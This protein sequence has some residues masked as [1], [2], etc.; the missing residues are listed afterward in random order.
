MSELAPT[1]NPA[2]FTVLLVEDSPME[3]NLLRAM[4]QQRGFQVVEAQNG[5]E[6]LLVL[7]KERP[8]AVVSDGVMP[9]LDG[10]QFCR[11]LKDDPATRHIPLILLTGQA[12]GLSRF[13]ARVC[14]ADRFLLKGRESTRVVEATVDL[15]ASL[16]E[17]I[18]RRD[19]DT[20]PEV[21]NWGHELGIDAIQLRLGKALE[22]QLL[23]T[24]MRGTIS[25]LATHRGTGADAVAKVLE[26]LH[27]LVL[28]GALHIVIQGE[29]GPVGFGRYGDA[30]G[31]EA[32]AHIEAAA[33]QSLG[34]A[35]P[36]PSTWEHRPPLTDEAA[37]LLDPI[38]FS[39]PIG[40]QDRPVLAWL[41]VN[42]GSRAFQ[43]YERLFE[44]ACQELGRLLDLIE[45][46]NRMLQAEEA[47]R[48]A[49]KRGSLAL[50][51]GGVAHDFNNLFQSI[52]AHVQVAE[53]SLTD[54][55]GKSALAK[56]LTAV[57]RGADLGRR[58]LE[59]SGCMWG[60]VVPLDLN[61]LVQE[62]VGAH[63]DH[64]FTLELSEALP[65]IAGDPGQLRLALS[66]LVQ[67]AGEAIGSGNGRI[68]VSTSLS[69][70]R[71]LPGSGGRW[72]TELPVGR[73]VTIAVAD[74]G[75]GASAKVLERMFDPFFS[76]KQ[77]GR[78][79]S[80]AATLGI[81]KA[82]RAALQVE[83]RVGEGTTFHLW[84]PLADSLQ[85][86]AAPG[87]ATI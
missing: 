4:F 2:A 3:R 53:L 46:R 40:M 84:F 42:L 16:P 74:T 55:R 71:P 45:G 48:Q 5:A 75:C 73:N 19:R 14:G 82:H 64:P 13:W 44:V 68:K 83:S 86:V 78:G 35:A 39:L 26:L 27:E 23:E 54:E 80:L 8:D 21:E 77:F 85:P 70:D 58:M 10:Y 24:A 1:L 66:H 63:P 12:E 50:M 34:V 9:V 30:A 49:E 17:G 33:Q 62:V 7:A 51:A 25:R 57:R 38:I 28:P 60:P 52:M 6:A 59:A 43:E 20:T 81:L 47:L 22:H 36:W 61:G 11:L 67:N 79:M 65:P 87:M 76:T 72:F 15:L 29:H 69:G 56:A 41:T 37:E 32:R 31:P 18:V